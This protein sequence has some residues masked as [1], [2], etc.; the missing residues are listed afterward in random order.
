MPE[1]HVLRRPGSE[2]RQHGSIEKELESMLERAVAQ[3]E[4]IERRFESERA[5]IESTMY[6]RPW[7]EWRLTQLQTRRQRDRAPLVEL[8]ADVH[9]RLRSAQWLEDLSTLGA[10][11]IQ[12]N[13]LARQRQSLPH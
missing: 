4:D 7:K 9:Q 12:P 10:D 13:V 2:Q 8:V 3:L 6:A 11:D 1:L 5:A